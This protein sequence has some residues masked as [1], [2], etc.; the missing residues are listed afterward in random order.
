VDVPA[1]KLALEGARPNP[2][3]RQINIALSLSNDAHATLDVID[4]AGRIIASR[5]VGSLGAGPHVVPFN[6]GSAA[7]PGVCWLRLTQGGRS[8]LAKAAVIR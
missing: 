8:L 4:V 1:P 3:V 7:H 5:E 2:A 6:L